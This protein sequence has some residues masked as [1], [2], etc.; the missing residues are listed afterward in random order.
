[1]YRA[2]GAHFFSK[3]IVFS[4]KLLTSVFLTADDVPDVTW[5]KSET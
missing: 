4:F 5:E 2:N 1:M 3:V